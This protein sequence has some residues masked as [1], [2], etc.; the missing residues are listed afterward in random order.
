[1]SHQFKE[2]AASLKIKLLNS[3]P[4]YAQ[5]NSQAESS[6]KILIRLIKK[7]IEESLRRW[8]KVLSE[9]L[10]AR[11][12]SRHGATK[13]TPFELVFG[14][15]AVL[16]IE[17][18]LQGC[19]VEAQDTL[20][21][22]EYQELMMDRI[23]EV[24]NGQ[25]IALREIEKEKLRIAQAYNRKVKENSF[26]INDLVWKT[27]LPIGSR[28]S[29]FGKWPPSWEGPFWVVGIMLGNS[30]FVETLEGV[31][32]AKHSMENTWKSFTWV[33]GKGPNWT[34]V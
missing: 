31:K 9:A 32:W 11:W 28:D 23:D 16:P 15:E 2:F 26:Q 30:Y 7:K 20:S 24:T 14:K 13:V 25:L 10:W 8:H 12:I 4:Y 3:S 19:R 29:K 34:D 1:M 33:Y 5:A 6:N 17:V 27:I 18:N 22:G 21:A